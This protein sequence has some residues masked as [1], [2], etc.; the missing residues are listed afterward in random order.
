MLDETYW[1]KNTCEREGNHKFIWYSRGFD[2]NPIGLDM[3]MNSLVSSNLF[4]K[5][6]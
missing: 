4:L 3:R 2:I 6:I 1:K 5:D